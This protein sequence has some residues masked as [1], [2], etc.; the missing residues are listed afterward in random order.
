MDDQTGRGVPLVELRTVS[1]VVYVSDSA[2]WIAI[3]DPAHLGRKVF[4]TVSSHGYTFPADGFGMHGRAIDT[5]PGGITTLQIKRVNKAERLYRIGGEG[6][7]RDSVILGK[8]APIKEPLLNAQ[9]VG[10]DSVQL[11]TYQGKLW[12]FWGDTN[13]QSYPLGHFFTASATSELPSAG[14]LHPNVGI[15]LNYFVGTDGFSRGMFEREG[16]KLFWMDGVFVVKDGTG[17]EH[18]IA[19]VGVMQSL[20]KVLARRLVELDDNTKMFR[21]LC[22]LPVAGPGRPHGHA[23]PATVNGKSYIYFADPLP[24]VRVPATYEAAIEA[25]NYEVFTCVADGLKTVDTKTTLDRDDAGKL[26][27]SWKRDTILLDRDMT[28]KL[29]K[30]GK[31]HKDEQYLR[32]MDAETGSPVV[33]HA[34]SVNWNVYRQKW[35]MIANQI[36][37]KSSLLGEVY[38]LEAEKIEGPWT[39]ATKVV[40]HDRYSFYN[41]KHH[42]E[43]DQDGGRYIFFEGT[44]SSTFDR[45]ADITPRY[46]YNQMMYRL[47]LKRFD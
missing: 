29:E 42:V 18:M 11:A 46:D 23:F 19:A 14:G 32:P 22:E 17:K 26:N 7:Y 37:G 4:F 40:T 3:D 30:L 2:G 43:F 35:V 31:L 25:S 1:N 28:E 12:W 39:K 44:Y 10:Q 33:L 20:E 34:G 8:P 15:N 5:T 21:T 9:V 24:N 41:P 13:R 38:Y 45:K 6:I 36:G 27:W 47:D 16:P